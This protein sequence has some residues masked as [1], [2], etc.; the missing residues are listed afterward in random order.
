MVHNWLDHKD[1]NPWILACV[2]PGLT[3]MKPADFFGMSFNTNIGESAHASAQREGI[4]LSLV[5][6][7]QTGLRFDRRFFD[8][9]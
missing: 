7:I 2:C 4:H 9:E 6:A 8:S 3:E 1:K 5:G